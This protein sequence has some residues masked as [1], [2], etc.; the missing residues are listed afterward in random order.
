[1]LITQTDNLAFRSAVATAFA[2]ALRERICLNPFK[3]SDER[4]RHPK[5]AKSPQNTFPA[6]IPLFM[7]M[8]EKRGWVG[9]MNPHPLFL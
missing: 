3:H 6:F 7:L 8:F 2:E 4:N 9:F 1:M 5:G